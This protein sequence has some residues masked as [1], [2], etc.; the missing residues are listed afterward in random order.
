MLQKVFRF[1]K[2]A[3]FGFKAVGEVEANAKAFLLLG[4]GKFGATGDLE[5][6]R[7]KSNGT[8]S[9]VRLSVDGYVESALAEQF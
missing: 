1:L 2:K 6:G 9:L 4:T 3:I 8:D 5:I 7:F